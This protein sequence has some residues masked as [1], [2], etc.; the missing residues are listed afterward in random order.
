MAAFA[1]WHE[2]HEAARRALAGEPGIVAHAALETYSVLT[3]LPPPHRA[4]ARL[5]VEFLRDRFGARYYGLAEAEY[6]TLAERLAGL[7]ITGG[8]TYDGLIAIVA[9]RQGAPL[10]TCDERAA[11]TYERCGTGVELLA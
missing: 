5:V 8:A 9:G 7:G 4:P 11:R 1:S 10:V 3:R 6:P 2:R